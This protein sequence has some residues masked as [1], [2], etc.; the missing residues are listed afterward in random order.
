M[1]LSNNDPDFN[2]APTDGSAINWHGNTYT[3]GELWA[4]QPANGWQRFNAFGPPGDSDMLF[5][6]Y[7]TVPEP[8]AGVSLAVLAGLLA[9]RARSRR[10]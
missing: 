5:R 8:A 2:T 7:M 9:M 10:S 3:R 1:V 6:T 4:W